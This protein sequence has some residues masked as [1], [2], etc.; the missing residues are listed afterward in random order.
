MKINAI[1]YTSISRIEHGN[2]ASGFFAS[3]GYAKAFRFCMLLKTGLPFYLMMKA[4]FTV[5]WDWEGD[6]NKAWSCGCWDTQLGSLNRPRPGITSTA[7]APL[8]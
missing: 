3:G 7:E 5:Q 6:N 1:I 8:Q 2:E 4:A